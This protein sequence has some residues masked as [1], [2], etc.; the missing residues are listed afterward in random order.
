MPH[1]CNYP[2]AAYA[3]REGSGGFQSSSK[4]G[5]V[6]TALLPHGF[7]G[8]DWALQTSDEVWLAWSAAKRLHGRPQRVKKLSSAAL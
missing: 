8:V 2:L 5:S 3:Q 6:K 4:R 7:Y 1:P